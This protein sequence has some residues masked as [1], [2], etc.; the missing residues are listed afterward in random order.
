MPAGGADVGNLTVGHILMIA[1]A[2]DALVAA[3]YVSLWLRNRDHG[4]GTPLYARARDAR[5]VAGLLGAL[6]LVFLG[7]AFLTPLHETPLL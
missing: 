4:P 5:R 3:I 6:V 1:A 7:L 2:A